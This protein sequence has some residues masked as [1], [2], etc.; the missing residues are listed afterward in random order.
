MNIAIIGS[1]PTGISV[2]RELVKTKHNL[3]LLDSDTN[4]KFTNKNSITYQNLSP[5]YKNSKFIQ[6]NNQFFKYN[7]LKKN[8][9][10]F[11]TSALI[12]GGLSNFWG[13]GIEIPKKA[14]IQ[15]HGID[16]DYFLKVSK[17][18]QKELNLFSPSKNIKI[19]N[20]IFKNNFF[21]K[22]DFMKLA[23]KRNKGLNNSNLKSYLENKFIYNSADQIIELSK[24]KNFNYYNDCFIEKI[25]KVKNKLQFNTKSSKIPKTLKF[26]KVIICAGT[27]GSPLIIARSLLLKKIKFKIFHTP[28]IRLTY[29]NFLLPFRKFFNILKNNIFTFSSNQKL[30]AAKGT[31]V[32]GSEIPNNYFNVSNYNFFFRYFKKFILVGV[33][34]INYNDSF[35]ELNYTN[36]NISTKSNNKSY[37]ISIKY[38]KRK[39]NV[40]LLKKFF[41]PIPFLNFK[42]FAKGSDSHY[43]SSLTDTNLINK[44]YELKELKNVFVADSSVIQPGLFYPTYF[45]IVLS[46]II[47]KKILNEEI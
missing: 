38:F 1:G 41:I 27:V 19:I 20:K 25:Y 23:I 44:K 36:K 42:F 7:K 37:K 47:V 21:F 29:L 12:K 35:F 30:F 10:I 34:F 18:V 24:F 13:G 40:N 39:L 5:K 17:Q 43:T 16:Y 46:K 11:I 14:Y 31:L 9:N 15:R 4:T 22:F 8:S 45:S 33:S 32:F 28:M 6:S 3:F 2:C 26:D